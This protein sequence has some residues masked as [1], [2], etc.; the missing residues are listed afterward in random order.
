MAWYDTLWGLAKKVAPLVA[1]VVVDKNETDL[2]VS[3][4][5][6]LDDKIQEKKKI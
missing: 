5:T 2:K 3:K 4:F 6:N 1:P